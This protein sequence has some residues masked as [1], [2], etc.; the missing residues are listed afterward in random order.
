MLG[1]DKIQQCEGLPEYD[2]MAL[3]HGEQVVEINR[4]IREGED[5]VSENT[6]V[7]VDDKKS[8]A[9]IT[10]E[11]KT[12]SEGETVATNYAKLFI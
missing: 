3:L 2:G 4:T 1:L 10:I 12:L 6:I 5:L 11:S 8:G 7:D 9:L